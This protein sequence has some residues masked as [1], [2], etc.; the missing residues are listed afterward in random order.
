MTAKITGI[1]TRIEKEKEQK[2]NEQNKKEL[3]ALKQTP[4]S[5]TNLGKELVQEKLK[6]R[7]LE[8][9]TQFLGTELVRM[10]LGG[11]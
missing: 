9:D 2:E 8:N 1:L 7:K 10:K 5:V 11:E 3:K 4:Y 6:R